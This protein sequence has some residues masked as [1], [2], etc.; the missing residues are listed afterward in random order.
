METK[1]DIEKGQAYILKPGAK[2]EGF[3]EGHKVRI[4]SYFKDAKTKH[5]LK[6]IWIISVKNESGDWIKPMDGKDIVFTQQLE[7]HFNL[8]FSPMAQK[9]SRLTEVDE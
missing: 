5:N 2:L 1:M 4:D 3:E 6:G 9:T 8:E 7:A